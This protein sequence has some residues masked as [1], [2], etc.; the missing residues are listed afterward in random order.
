MSD[1]STVTVNSTTYDLKDTKARSHGTYY[2]KGT[3]TAS[4]NEWT[5]N[6]PDVDEL[7]EGLIIDY[8]LPFAGTSSAATLNLT[9]KNDVETGPIPLY[10]TAATAINTHLAVSSVGQFIYQTVTISNVEYTGWWLL[11]A[12]YKN[13]NTTD[14]TNLYNGSSAYIANSAVYRYQLL[15][16]MDKYE[17]RLTPLNNNSN[18]TGTTKS[19]LTNVEFDPFGDIF[20]Y[21]ST[22]TAAANA[23]M[24]TALYYHRNVVDLR[25]TFNCGQTLT[26]HKDFYLVVSPQSNGKVKIASSTP[27]AQDL[28]TTNDGYLYIFLGRTYSTYQFALYTDHPVYYHDG[29]SIRRLEDIDLATQSNPG[30]MSSADKT[31][32]DGIASGAN[33]YSHPTGDGNLHVPANGTGNNGKFLKASGTAGSYSWSSLAKSDIGLDNVTNDAQ[34][35]KSL[36]TAVGDIIYYSASGTPARLAIGSSNQILK[37]VNGV[38]AW[39]TGGGGSASASY[40]SETETLEFIF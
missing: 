14:I 39:A 30:L 36:G 26:A 1:I 19:M 31:K 20:Y 37:V 18:T 35:P 27:W 6:L 8:W 4:T 29:T 33:N 15:F 16:Q 24:T 21:N 9:L 12:Y 11:K 13:D 3:Q 28:P 32:L 34:I 17:N 5:G 40:D 2:V 23:N 7:Y 38:P 25:Y 10:Y 22:T